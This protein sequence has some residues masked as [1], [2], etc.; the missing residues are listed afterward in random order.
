[1]KVLTW[2]INIAAMYIV[3]IRFNLF[4][5]V[6]IIQRIFDQGVQGTWKCLN[7]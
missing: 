2:Y 4:W 7:L 5:P 6:Y 3:Y 1:M